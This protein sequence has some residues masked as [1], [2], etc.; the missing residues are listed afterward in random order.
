MREIAQILPSPI[1]WFKFSDFIRF[2]GFRIGF[3]G[4]FSTSSC[5]SSSGSRLLFLLLFSFFDAIS[6]GDEILS[7]LILVKS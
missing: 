2:S 3:S 6:G 4:I 7:V 5:E 1:S